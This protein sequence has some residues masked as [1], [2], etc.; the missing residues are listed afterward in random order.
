M[1]KSG[2]ASSILHVALEKEKNSINECRQTNL[3]IHAWRNMEVHRAHSA[4]D[5]KLKK[6]KYGINSILH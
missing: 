2:D 5:K 3:A 4:K 6:K 1:E